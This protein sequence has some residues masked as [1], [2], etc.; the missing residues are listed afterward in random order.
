MTGRREVN[1]RCSKTHSGGIDP[2]PRTGCNL[3]CA[4]QYTIS[5]RESRIVVGVH[6][7]IQPNSA[8][9]EGSVAGQKPST[10]LLRGKLVVRPFSRVTL[11][12]FYLWFKPEEGIVLQEGIGYRE[13]IPAPDWPRSGGNSR[14]SRLPVVSPVPPHAAA[15]RSDS[16]TSWHRI[17]GMCGAGSYRD[18]RPGP[19]SGFG[20]IAH[21]SGEEPRASGPARKGCCP[22]GAWGSRRNAVNPFQC[23]S[24]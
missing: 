11:L 17:T 18:H 14:A 23:R 9:P 5:H 13:S 20:K 24:R 22:K 7:R 12:G 21:F 8:F 6:A 16:R 19:R 2:F 10:I 1:A 15:V 3:N 4:F